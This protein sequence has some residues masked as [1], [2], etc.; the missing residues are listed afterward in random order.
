[1]INRIVFNLKSILILVFYFA[2]S[3]LAYSQNGFEEYENY[4]SNKCFNCNQS[5]INSFV[6]RNS[7]MADSVLE[8]NIDRLF[9]K[10]DKIDGLRIS[11]KREMKKYL[12]HTYKNLVMSRKKIVFNYNKLTEQG[13]NTYYPSLL[14][15][16]YTEKIIE[17]LL[18]MEMTL[19]GDE[20]N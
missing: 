14:Y 4:I 1:M 19:F 13:F 12:N 11:K 18:D 7:L 8:R 3:N 17:I 16:Y 2:I 15:W 6:I 20:V 5:E 10:V 9:F